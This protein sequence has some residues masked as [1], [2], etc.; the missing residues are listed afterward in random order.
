MHRLSDSRCPAPSAGH[1]SRAF[2]HEQRCRGKADAA[3]RAGDDAEAVAKA[4]IQG[5][6][7][8]NAVTTILLVRHGETDW[9]AGRR[10]Q[11]HTDRPLNDIGR[12][13]A[14]ALAREL[15][16]EHLDAVYSSDLSRAHETARA[17]ADAHGLEVHALPEL[18]ERH[19]GTWEGLTDEEIERRF[20]EAGERVLGDG[21]T[22]EDMARRVFDAL[23]RIADE[24][25]GGRVL[26]VSHG[27]PLRAV[28]RHC[29]ADTVDRVANCHVLR[30]E[31]GGGV[32]REID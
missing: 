13:Q 32:L 30:L 27:G 14:G 23:Q 1:N 16:D 19:F 29:G 15:A 11:G 4:E 12:E 5:A 7:S 18:R 2:R 25:P 21:E 24:H 26:V 28:L 17:V 10:L 6:A 22:R 3:G 20:P 31:A 9:N 8:L